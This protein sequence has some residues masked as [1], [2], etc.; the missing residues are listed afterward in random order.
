M[1]NTKSIFM[2]LLIAALLLAAMTG[3]GASSSVLTPG[4][5]PGGTPEVPADATTEA[6]AEESG[7]PA[8]PADVSADMAADVQTDK[9]AGEQPVP[10]AQSAEAFVG[11]WHLDEGSD[12]EALSGYFPGAAE[13][14]SGMEIRSDGSISWFIGADGAAGTYTY[15]GDTPGAAR[16]AIRQAGHVVVT[17][18]DMLHSG[19]LPHHTKWVKLFEN[20]K[21]IVIDEIHTYRGIFASAD[22]DVSFKGHAAFNNHFFQLNYTIRTI[23]ICIITKLTIRIYTATKTTTITSIIMVMSSI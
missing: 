21:F 17:N 15:D 7:E 5:A 9:T 14:G 13:F 1:K 16:R 11:L 12:L 6:P 19:I 18:P 2:L 23:M 4:S 10:A 22:V 3:C 8:D 20:L